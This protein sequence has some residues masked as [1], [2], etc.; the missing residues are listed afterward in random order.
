MRET[1]LRETR[2]TYTAI[3]LF[4]IDPK[5]SRERCDK[6]EKETV[7]SKSVSL[8]WTSKLVASN[9]LVMQ[10]TKSEEAKVMLLV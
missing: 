10:S 5:P 3:T 8:I 9:D 4:T 1:G 6:C 7:L 2:S